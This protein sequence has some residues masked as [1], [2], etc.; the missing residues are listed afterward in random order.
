M[1]PTLV[2]NSKFFCVLVHIKT[3]DSVSCGP[4][5]RRATPWVYWQE[6]RKRHFHTFV[7]RWYLIRLEPNLLQS[8]PPARG[9]YIPNLK[10]ITQAIPRYEW[11]KFRF[12]FFFVF[13]HTCKNCYNKQTR[14][15]IALTFGTQKGNPTANPSI[16]FGTNPMNGSGVMTDYSRKTRSICCHAYRVNRF[17]EWVENCYVDGVTIV[18]VPFGG[19]KGIEIK[20]T[21]IW[22]K[23]QPVSQLRDRFLWIKKY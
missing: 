3:H 6:E 2:E 23:T 5:S 9:V 18:G 12:F 19:L 20:T 4:R 13:S 1:V 15:P 11:P 22:H 8:F 17:M 21:E 10:E 16:N 7:S 14:T